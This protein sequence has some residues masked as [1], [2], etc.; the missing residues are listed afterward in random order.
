MAPGWRGGAETVEPYV[1]G[2]RAR[3]LEAEALELPLGAAERVVP[4]FLE[5]AGPDLIAAGRSF[6][7][8]VASLAAA[9]AHFAGVIAFSYP[10]RDSAE[11]RSRHWP[12]IGCPVLIV[13]G[14]E[15]EVAD[16]GELRRRLPLLRDGRLVLL[17]GA[18]HDLAPVLAQAL[19]EAARFARR[20][21]P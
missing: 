11:L 5:R 17:P 14:E 21:G 9:Q 10:L 18:G 20:L 1:A 8:R 19:D 12:E 3:G 7:G 6:G 15:D 16:P 2:L 4:R 13:N